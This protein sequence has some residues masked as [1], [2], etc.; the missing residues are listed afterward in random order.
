MR[1]IVFSVMGVSLVLLKNLNVF[2]CFV[3][4]RIVLL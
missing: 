2:A 1:G 3:G 4:P